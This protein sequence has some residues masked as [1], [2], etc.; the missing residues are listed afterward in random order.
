L[1][2]VLVWVVRPARPRPTTAV[3]AAL[4]EL[5][6]T[7][8]VRLDGRWCQSQ[9]GRTNPFTGILLEYFPGGPLQSRSMVSN[10]LLEGLSE[11]WHT[12]GQLQARE[13][14]HTNFSNGPRTK[15]Y[16][17]GRKLS[18]ATIVQGKMQGVFRRWYENG[19]LAEEI[20]MRDG[21]IEGVG[22]GYYESGYL[23]TEITIHD[24]QVVTAKNW[25]D[26]TQS[27]V[28]Q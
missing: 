11:F 3:V 10:G 21:K 19:K 22:H 13:Y 2:V 16:P 9:A 23:K 18:E 14:Y 15:W 26:G 7:N 24:G 4:P 28:N 1:V 5:A 6:S 12:N 8:L 27:G 17:D 25:P 20:P